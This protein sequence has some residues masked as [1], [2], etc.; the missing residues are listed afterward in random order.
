MLD[1]FLGTSC[2]TTSSIACDA[3]R[4]HLLDRD[5]N[6]KESIKGINKKNDN[7][8]TKATSRLSN[9]SVRLGAMESGIADLSRWKEAKNNGKLE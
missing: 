1:T 6:E 9:S 7:K 4:T 2:S 3:W 8:P 5:D